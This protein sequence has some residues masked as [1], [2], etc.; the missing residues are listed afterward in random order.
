MVEVQLFHGYGVGLGEEVRLIHLQFADDTL[1]IGEK[2]WRN[3][4]SMRAVLLL[5]EEISRLKVNFNKSML[6][7]LNVNESW[8]A[9]MS[10]VMNCRKGV[11]SF[12][13]LGT[14]YWWGFKK[15]EFLETRC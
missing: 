8:L 9:E 15:V 1:I 10:V 13:V 2:S 11:Y 4:R 6:I 5:F 7:D 3:V 12:C 14:A